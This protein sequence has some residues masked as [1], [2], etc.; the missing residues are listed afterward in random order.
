MLIEEE[1]TTDVLIVGAGPAGLMMACQ[2]SLFHIGFRIIDK[3]D[4]PSDYSGALIIHARTM[5]LFQQMNLARK[6]VGKATKVKAL[7]VFIEGKKSFRLPTENIGN[8]VTAFPSMYM[9][10]QSETERLL[11]DYL[12]KNGHFVEWNTELTDLAEQKKGVSVLLKKREGK[13]ETAV[14]QYLA[15]ADGGRS[16]VRSALNIPFLGKTDDADL[17]IMEC[18]SDVQLQPDEIG[19]SFSRN[20]TAGFFP[21]PGDRWRIDFTLKNTQTE[22]GKIHFND[23]Q[24]SF[25][26]Q[27]KLKAN[28]RNPDFFSVFHS[29][30]LVADC[31]QTNRCFLIGDAA[32]V[33]TP[34]GAQG[35]NSGFQ[36][37][38]NLAWKMALVIRKNA[39]PKILETY[40]KERKPVA[41]KVSQST[42]RFFKIVVSEKTSYRLIRR[43]VFPAGFAIFFR[44]LKNRKFQEK[45]FKSIS[46]IGV[47]YNK[48]LLVAEDKDSKSPLPKPGDYYPFTTN[49]HL[50]TNDKSTQPLFHLFIFSKNEGVP[51][52]LRVADR[53]RKN[54]TVKKIPFHGEIR[55]LQRKFGMAG[56]S[57]ILVRPDRFVGC[58]SGKNDAN[59]LEKYLE[60][61]LNKDEDIQ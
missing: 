18:R 28:I 27:T 47:H 4:S 25:N 31:F 12:Q 41:E 37:A 52:L 33:F 8:E 7:S 57:W 16:T 36:D 23:V 3:K 2:L 61:I 26:R 48:N 9:L 1:N 21:L 19:F 43:S 38:Q 55:S 58:R 49:K 56:T 59:R 17:G 45:V 15:G 60:K 22:T 13:V 5:E 42:N 44:L 14:C 40:E 46:G 53:Y 6:V 29:H 24:K 35:M 32:H 54:V 34:V 30:S 50:I 51:E 11:I 39:F 10:E 20:A